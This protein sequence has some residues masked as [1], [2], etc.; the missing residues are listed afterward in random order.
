[1]S[2]ANEMLGVLERE[3]NEMQLSLLSD[4]CDLCHCP[5]VMSQ[6]ELDAHCDECS[7]S[8][9]LDALLERQRAV[10]MGKVMAIVAEE[11]TPKEEKK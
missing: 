6:E 5:H 11:M 2:K 3:L 8:Q 7:I 9:D 4:I 1:M 10:M